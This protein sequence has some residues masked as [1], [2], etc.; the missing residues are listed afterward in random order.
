MKLP[1]TPVPVIFDMDGLL[2]DTEACFRD[3]CIGV[4]AEQG[5]HMPPSLFHQLIGIPN[6]DSLQTLRAHY[7]ADF[8]AEALYAAAWARFHHE[9]DATTLLKD[10]VHELLDALDELGLPRAVATSSPREAVATHLAPNGLVERFDVIVTREDYERGKPAPDPFLTAAV[11]LR[12]DPSR[13]LAL[14]D[15]HN[16][17]RAAHAAG[18]MTIMVPDLWT[19]RKR[20]EPSAS[21][22]PQVCMTSSRSSRMRRPVVRGA[23]QL[24]A[25][26]P[27]PPHGGNSSL[28]PSLTH[29]DLGEVRFQLVPKKLSPEMQA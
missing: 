3:I 22:S 17:V 26:G 10:G 15:S 8:G 12:V 16:G 29:H 25:G 20:C 7:G 27:L 24:L 13:C 11:R 9:V 4:A 6:A 28:C 2:L 21:R 18:M 14:E 23:R 1:R 5:R 19:Q